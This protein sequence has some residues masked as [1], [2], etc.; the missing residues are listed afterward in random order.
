MAAPQVHFGAEIP[1]S[2]S[3]LNTV[4]IR[5]SGLV[6]I[7]SCLSI[8][9]VLCWWSFTGLDSAAQEIILAS[10]RRLDRI[11]CLLLRMR[12]KPV[13]L[14]TPSIN[15]VSLYLAQNRIQSRDTSPRLC[16]SPIRQIQ[17]I[18]LRSFA[19]G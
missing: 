8:A 13:S 19:S 11:S 3:F 12:S 7:H 10:D 2:V 17:A 9:L 14:I 1:D 4:S 15:C 16:E 6:Q 18:A 5:Q